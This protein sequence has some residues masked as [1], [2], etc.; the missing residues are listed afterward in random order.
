MA[1]IALVR[2]IAM[3]QFLCRCGYR[4]G[5]RTPTGVR[6]V[7]PHHRRDDGTIVAR[8]PHC[9]WKAFIDG[10]RVAA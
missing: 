3:Q 2:V 7:V 4:L 5:D 10:E 9:R 8:C 1:A 6:V